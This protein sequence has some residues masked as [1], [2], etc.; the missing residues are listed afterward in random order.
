MGWVTLE[1]A[2]PNPPAETY[3]QGEA[4]GTNQHTHRPE[5]LKPLKA[6]ELLIH[7]MLQEWKEVF[8]LHCP[9]AQHHHATFC[10]QSSHPKSGRKG[11]IET[12]SSREREDGRDHSYRDIYLSF[13]SLERYFMRT[14]IITDPHLQH[15][16]LQP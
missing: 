8:A 14:H 5:T 3:M 9:S 7:H 4:Q 6:S 11:E 1:R 2:V 10:L 12:Y 16:C 13:V 15:V